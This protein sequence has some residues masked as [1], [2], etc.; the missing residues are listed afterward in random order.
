MMS[1]FRNCHLVLNLMKISLRKSVK[2]V[3]QSK[4]GILYYIYH[5]K[6]REGKA[7]YDGCIIDGGVGV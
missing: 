2:L 3:S 1:R 6:G 5:I 7:K 4:G